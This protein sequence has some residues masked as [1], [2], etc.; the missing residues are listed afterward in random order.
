MSREAQEAV[1]KLN[2]D[3]AAGERSVFLRRVI[4][5]S[6]D[7]GRYI[8]GAYERTDEVT[9]SV[10]PW[11]FVAH[12]ASADERP[13]SLHPPGSLFDLGEPVARL[14]TLEAAVFAGMMNFKRPD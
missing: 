7:G 11:F 4:P 2:R 12:D 8:L 5:N 14:D 10:S 9:M 13:Y 3:F 6:A 1:K